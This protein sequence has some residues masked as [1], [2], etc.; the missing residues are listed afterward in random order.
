MLFRPTRSRLLAY[1]VALSAVAAG[2]V[3]ACDLNPQPLPPGFTAPAAGDVGDGGQTSAPGAAVDAGSGTVLG[4]GDAGAT[5]PPGADGGTPGVPVVDG[6]IDAGEGGGKSDA[7]DAG[8]G[9]AG[10]AGEEDAGDGS[11]DA[12]SDGG[13]A[14]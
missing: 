14:G 6:G 11:S 8:A 2:A 1:C 4:P 3:V 7:G 12:A 13:D 9:D 10:D 5:N